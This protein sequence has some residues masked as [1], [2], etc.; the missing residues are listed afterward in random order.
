M[1]REFVWAGAFKRA[2]KS[3]V[4]G[5]AVETL[6]WQ[7]LDVFRQNPFD[8]SLKTHRLA[9]KLERYWAFSVAYDCRV[10]FRFLSEER[11]LLVDIGSH[12]EVY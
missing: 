4:A 2:I 7:K 5:Q 3:R 12:E 6:F 10:I 11:A 9:G 1:I 8:A